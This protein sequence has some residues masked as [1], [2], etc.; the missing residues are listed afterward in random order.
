MCKDLNIGNGDKPP[1]DT[2]KKPFY[3]SRTNTKAWK[4]WQLLSAHARQFDGMSGFTY[5]LNIRDIRAE[6]KRT[7]DPDKIA[8]RVMLIDEHYIE[9]CSKERKDKN[10]K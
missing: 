7:S 4:V 3:L 10:K 9:M 1:C 8:N 2:C 6:A 5:P